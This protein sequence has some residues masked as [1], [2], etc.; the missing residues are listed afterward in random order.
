MYSWYK[1][2]I[3]NGQIQLEWEGGLSLAGCHNG[4]IPNELK[5]CLSIDDN[6]PIGWSIPIAEKWNAQDYSVIIDIKPNS[7]EIFLCEL[8]RVFGFSYRTWS[9]IML[10]LKRLYDGITKEELDKRMFIY[11]Q[12]AE[13]IFTMLYLNGGISDGK[14]SGTWNLPFGRVTALLFWP[15]AMTFFVEKMRDT[16]PEFLVADIK[17]IE[18]CR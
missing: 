18:S 2:K 4:L 12:E 8:D 5:S 15:E 11:P 3:E 6:A 7:N 17:V 1:R 13:V 16:N 9:P 10:R 14:L